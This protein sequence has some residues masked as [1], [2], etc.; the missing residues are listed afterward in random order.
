MEFKISLR[1]QILTLYQIFLISEILKDI[2]ACYMKI[3]APQ[4][5]ILIS[6]LFILSC[7][8]KNEEKEP[9][10]KKVSVKDTIH[11]VTPE[12]ENAYSSIDVSPMDMS[13][14]PVDYPKLKMNNKGTSLPVMRVIY[15][16]PHLQGRKL[17]LDLLKHGE[18]WRLGANEATEIQFYRN[19]TI[20]NKQIR[21]GRYILYCV[22]EPNKWNIMLNSNIDSWGLKQDTT[23]DIQRFE[24][25]V[26]HHNRALA[27]LTLVFE[28]TDSGANLLMGWDEELAKLPINF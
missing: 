7:N 23:K 8:E 16:R 1:L 3:I 18:P 26:T 27:Y 19:V 25:P 4:L 12:T 10:D 24:I 11:S 20:Q 9:L 13:Y 15:G 22:P 17:F 2:K 21:A 5:S 14:Y 28:K 6:I